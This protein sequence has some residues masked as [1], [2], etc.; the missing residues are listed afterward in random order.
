MS[1]KVLDFSQRHSAWLKLLRAN[2]G[3][4]RNDNV[5]FYAGMH[6]Y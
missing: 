1:T 2:K 3:G 6:Q 4:Q 5:E